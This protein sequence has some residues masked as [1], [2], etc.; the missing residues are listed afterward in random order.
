VLPVIHYLRRDLGA[1]VEQVEELASISAEHENSLLHAMV[2]FWRAWL[3]ADGGRVDEGVNEMG[4][5]LKQFVSS[6]LAA[7]LAV[8]V[9]EVCISH[10]LVDRGLVTV[11]EAL[12]DSEKA[13]VFL[14]ELH[15][16]KGELI[17]L[18]KLRSEAESCF[19]Q[20]IEIARCQGARF[21]ELRATTSLSRL[22]HDIGCRDEARSR[23]G[24]IYDWFTEGFELR[25]LQDAKQLLNDF[26][27]NF[28]AARSLACS[29]RAPTRAP[30]VW[31]TKGFATIALIE[32]RE[33]RK[34][35]WSKS[36]KIRLKEA[37]KTRL[38]ATVV[39]REGGHGLKP[40]AT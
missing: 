39:V 40:V 30:Q 7:L 6:P 19:R 18:R 36:G 37:W 34:K 16:L 1:L 10:G 38:I 25:D 9:P 32:A 8:S 4:R 33:R 2:A 23:L 22:L 35:R 15:R 26:N 13:P 5:I 28:D 14:A 3:M 27:K 20:A 11:D 12:N 24:E 29:L 17:L 21:F 31:F